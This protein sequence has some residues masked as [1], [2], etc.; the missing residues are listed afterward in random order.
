LSQPHYTLPQA[1]SADV[2]EATLE[3]VTTLQSPRFPRLL[4][5]AFTALVTVAV[6]IVPAFGAS[7]STVDGIADSTWSTNGSV[8]ATVPYG[9]HYLIIGGDFTSLRS[10]PAGVAGGTTLKVNNL[11]M[12]DT[13]TGAAVASFHP[14]V[15]E[16]NFTPGPKSLV[17]ALALRTDTLYVGGQFTSIGGSPHYNVGAVTVDPTLLTGT[18]D[19]TFNATVGIPGNANEQG[20]IVYS[21]LPGTDGLYLGGAF[22][23]VDGKGANKLAKVNFDGSF[24]NTFKPGVV[25]GAIHSLVWATDHQ[26][27]FVGGAFGV[28]GG[29]SHWSI[30]RISPTTGGLDAWQIPPGDVLIGTSPHFG[31]ICWSLVATPTRLFAGCGQ[32]PNYA[33]AFALDNGTTGNRTWLYGTPGNVQAI[34]LT[35]DGGS[36]IIGG[37]FGT[38][39]TMSVCVNKYAKNLAIL[40]NIGGTSTPSIDCGFLPQFWGPDPFGGVWSIQTNATQIWAGGMFTMDNCTMGPAHP[41]Q[42]SAIGCP[43]G[44]GQRGI[45]RFSSP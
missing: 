31:M 33:A 23:K 21:I 7:A 16:E 14:A 42:G 12:I 1:T 27:I 40:H 11:A 2:G 43:N 15:L 41:H 26:T 10:K 44:I 36:L 6:A 29:Q 5:L 34:S 39:L 18:V 3:E 25:N 19:N 37:H 13:T 45:V 30:V 4:T 20:Y 28:F 35:Q 24:V 22:S 9:T 8:F 32:T 17:R 38:Y